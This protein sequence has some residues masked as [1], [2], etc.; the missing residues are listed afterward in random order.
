MNARRSLIINKNLKKGTK[1]SKNDILIKRPENG[2]APK[3]KN[4]IIGGTLK[5]KKLQDQVLFWNDIGK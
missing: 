2:I 4:K 3:Y 1:I 5:N